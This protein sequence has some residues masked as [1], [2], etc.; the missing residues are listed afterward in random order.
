M[1]RRRVGSFI[2]NR[3][4]LRPEND[5][6]QR[7]MAKVVILDVRTLWNRDAV[8]YY[9]QCA[10]FD[11]VFEGAMPPQYEVLCSGDPIKVNFRRLAPNG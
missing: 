3:E 7:L 10:D 11:E 9:A 4:F 5:L 6:A 8:E 2:V 1:N